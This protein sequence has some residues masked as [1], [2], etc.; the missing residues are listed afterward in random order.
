M[1][2]V[3]R[4]IDCF[5]C[6]ALNRAHHGDKLLVV[7]FVNDIHNRLTWICVEVE[8]GLG[9]RRPLWGF[10]KISHFATPVP[11]AVPWWF[12]RL[13]FEF[14]PRFDQIFA[15]IVINSLFK[16]FKWLFLSLWLLLIVLIARVGKMSH[17]AAVVSS[18]SRFYLIGSIF[19]AWRRWLIS[20]LLDEALLLTTAIAAIVHEAW[21]WRGYVM[22][23]AD[24]VVLLR[25]CVVAGL[26]VLKNDTSR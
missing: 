6:V 17:A 21:L 22:Q 20:Q 3:L 11:E 7:M 26:I 18:L 15:V 4:S 14:N 9:Q 10:P 16:G 19:H 12:E 5:G 1:V 25:R 24:E 2:L 23:L 13:F 8:A